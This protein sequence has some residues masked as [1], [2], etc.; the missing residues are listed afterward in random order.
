MDQKNRPQGRKKNV[1]GAG[2]DVYK[3]GEGLGTGRVGSKDHSSGKSAGGSSSGGGSVP[4]RAAA[5]GGGILAI[6]ILIFS[7]IKGGGLGGLLDSMKN[8]GSSG[9]G[10]GV[11][12]YSASS[13]GTVNT[14]VAKGSREKRTVI[15]GDNKDSVTIMVYLCGTDLESKYGMATSDIEEMKAASKKFGD[16]FNIIIYT[17]G[18]N[19]WKTSA[20]SSRVNQIYQIKDGKLK[21]LVDDDGKKAMTDPDNLGSFI[22]YCK[23]NF[24]ANRNELILWDHGGGSVSGYG[25]DE[26]NAGKGSMDL[27]KLKQALDKGGMTFDFIGFDA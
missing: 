22:K 20:I 9:G 6:G 1:T 21:E 26:K 10:T 23:K 25:Y 15:K 12:N 27:A 14:S 3:R 2:K 24:P 17:G 7:L 13:E 16:D 5:G 11:G 18:C 4:K 8:S 19:K